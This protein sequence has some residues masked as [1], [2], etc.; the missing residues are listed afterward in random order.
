M[1]NHNLWLR[2][3]EARDARDGI[4][5]ISAPHQLEHEIHAGRCVDVHQQR[6]DVLVL[7]LLH[8]ANLRIDVMFLM[9]ENWWVE[10][11][12]LTEFAH[13]INSNDS[14]LWQSWLI[15]KC[16]RV[17]RATTWATRFKHCHSRFVYVNNVELCSSFCS[18]HDSVDRFYVEVLEL[19]VEILKGKVAHFFKSRLMKRSAKN[20]W[21]ESYQCKEVFKLATWSIRNF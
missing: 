19:R 21:Q 7:Q 1:L 16:L 11:I 8:H 18:Q 17:C 20:F 9:E 14:N 5:E 15:G 3:G 4:E 10:E 12:S 13:K 6:D 2:F